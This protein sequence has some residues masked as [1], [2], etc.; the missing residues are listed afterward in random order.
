MIH[1]YAGITVINYYNLV[2]FRNISVNK[3]MEA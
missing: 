1:A 2:V 3:V